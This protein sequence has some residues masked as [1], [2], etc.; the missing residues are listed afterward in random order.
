MSLLDV[1]VRNIQTSYPMDETS[2]DRWPSVVL[3]IIKQVEVVLAGR[4]TGADKLKMARD[5][6]EALFADLKVKQEDTE[7]YLDIF[8]DLVKVYIELDKHSEIIHKI[9][10]KRCPLLKLC[11]R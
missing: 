9:A 3:F 8:D 6:A 10:K 1:I 5:V 7:L 2:L 11:C 4:A